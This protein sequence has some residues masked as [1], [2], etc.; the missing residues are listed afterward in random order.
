[1]SLNINK[2]DD[3]KLF[4]M[5]IATD[6]NW[7]IGVDNKLLTFVKQD[8]EF[9]KKITLDHVVIMGR[10]TADSLPSGYLKG[11][12]NIILSKTYENKIEPEII[13]YE[14]SIIKI[15]SI[16]KL[17]KYLNNTKLLNKKPF[18]VIG[19]RSIYLEFLQRDL[20]DRVFLTTYLKKFNNVD[21]YI[22][23]LLTLGFKYDLTNPYHIITGYELPKKAIING[24]ETEMEF[25]IH[26]LTI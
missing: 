26:T 25:T 17:L 14:T 3:N 24:R 11:R 7:G 9:F 22:P 8:M 12:T 20:I 6:L 16:D 10:K 4:D 18:I 21:T 1:M 2:S 13:D 15:N 19:G 5:I 23:D